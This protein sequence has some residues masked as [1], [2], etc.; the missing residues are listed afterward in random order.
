MNYRKKLFK[1]TFSEKFEWYQEYMFQS[2][3]ATHMSLSVFSLIGV[4][5]LILNSLSAGA[6]RAA[7][8]TDLHAFWCLAIFHLPHENW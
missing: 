2:T 4:F 6:G 8:H 5:N 3:G 1:F 7:S